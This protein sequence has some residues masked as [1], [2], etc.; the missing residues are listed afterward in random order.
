MLLFLTAYLLIG[1]LALVIIFPGRDK[2]PKEEDWASMLALVS[3]PKSRGEIF[4]EEVILPV[5]LAVLVVALWPL[6]V[7][8]GI[9]EW[10]RSRYPDQ[11]LEPPVFAIKQDHLVEAVAIE[12]IEQQERVHD[13]LGAVPD[14]P[15]GHLNSAWQGFREQCDPEARIWRFSSPYQSEWGNKEIRSGYVAVMPDGTIGPYWVTSRQWLEDK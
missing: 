4:L 9:R 13:P 2:G 1:L 11:S 15:F 10:H 14:R 3:P 12:A 7:V 5:I 8:Y 6:A